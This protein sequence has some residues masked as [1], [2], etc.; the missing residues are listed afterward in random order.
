MGPHH[1]AYWGHV[2]KVFRELIRGF[3]DILRQVPVSMATLTMQSLYLV[4]WQGRFLKEPHGVTSQKTFFIDT[5][6]KPQILHDQ[7]NVGKSNNNKV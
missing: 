4:S 3:H 2:P 6:V 5:A 1:Q 7:C